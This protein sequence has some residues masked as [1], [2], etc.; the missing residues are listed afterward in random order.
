MDWPGTQTEGELGRTNVTW[1]TA[2][3]LPDQ[4][5]RRLRFSAQLVYRSGCLARITLSLA[6]RLR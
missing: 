4:E 2:V 1:Q 3:L 5:A 6:A